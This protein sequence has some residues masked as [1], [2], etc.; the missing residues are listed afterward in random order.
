[1]CI[2]YVYAYLR[3]DGS[4]YYIGKG[5]DD[6]AWRHHKQDRIKTPKDKNRVVLL[7]TN[8]SEVGA[9][10]LER[11]MIRW[12]GRKDLSNG[13]LHNLTAGGEGGSGRVDTVEVRAKKSATKTGS[14]NPMF[15]IFGKNHPCSLDRTG[16][17]N[18]MYGKLGK[19]NPNFGQSR[20]VHAEKMRNKTWKL[21]NGKRIY[22]ER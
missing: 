20:P 11:R 19:D 22:S 5:K 9:F 3:K 17:N 13:I 12:Y 6:R 10:A 2:Y 8:L 7:E 4:P 14:L 1:M 15:G 18:P 21:V 16:S